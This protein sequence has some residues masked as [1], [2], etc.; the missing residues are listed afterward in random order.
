MSECKDGERKKKNLLY[1]EALEKNKCKADRKWTFFF[2]S[3]RGESIK[4]IQTEREREMLLCADMMRLKYR[5]V[6][7]L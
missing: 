4:V 2:L 5:Q 3:Y 6:F 1:L 7:C